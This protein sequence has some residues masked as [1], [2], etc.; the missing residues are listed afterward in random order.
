MEQL[1]YPGVELKR[2]PKATSEIASQGCADRWTGY[3][4][5]QEIAGEIIRI[6]SIM[7]GQL[8]V[9]SGEWKWIFNNTHAE[10]RSA[11]EA[12]D[13]TS[14]VSM[15]Q[16][17]FRSDLSFGLVSHSTFKA[18]KDRGE[19]A[20]LEFANSMLLDV[21]TWLE[22]CD[23]SPI[24][25]LEIPQV[26]NPYGVVIEGT[27]V[28]P[29]ACRHYYHAHKLK[30][31]MAHCSSRPT[32]LE[33]GGGY[34]GVFWRLWSNL[35]G[36]D[37]FCYINCDLEESLFLFYYFIMTGAASSQY[38]NVAPPKVKWA[39]DG[40]V[41]N[42]DAAKYDVI[43]VPA[44]RHSAL[45]CNLDIVYNA[46]SLSEMARDDVDRYFQTINRIR[47]RF[48]LH[49][50]SN[51]FPWSESS[52][53]HIE[54]LSRDFPVDHKSYEEVCRAVSPW[55]GANG[56]YREYLYIRKDILKK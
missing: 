56:R 24:E 25:A 36:S 8:S 23:S 52:R 4:S 49:Q 38:R 48:I 27:L 29:D 42:E 55:M 21:D 1:T 53:G 6:Y 47:P 14:L 32:I 20:L 35:Q 37:Q 16:N 31:L 45:D 12:A 17:F 43:L 19:E 40:Q 50:N 39:I 34:G 13:H 30:G 7:T 51:F 44:N 5:D 28:V 54:V 9:P 11:L 2:H 26:G 3:E 33:I 22:F 41:T 15:L 18:L 46:N 10:Y